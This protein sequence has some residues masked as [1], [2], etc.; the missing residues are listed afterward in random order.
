MAERCWH[1]QIEQLQAKVLALVEQDE[2]STEGEQ[3]E[4]NMSDAAE[5]CPSP[6]S[7]PCC[8]NR[9]PVH[10]CGCWCPQLLVRYF[11]VQCTSAHKPIARALIHTPIGCVGIVGLLQ[12]FAPI[13]CS[14]CTYVSG[15][16][17]MVS[18]CR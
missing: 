17:L 15:T 2:G 4:G 16:K 13:R 9:R 5:V 3:A 18:I 7:S 6:D 10:P 8:L 11:F 1:V 12:P 14:P